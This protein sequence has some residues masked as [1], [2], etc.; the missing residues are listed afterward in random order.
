MSDPLDENLRD[1]LVAAARGS[2]GAV[3][4]VGGLLGEL[5]TSTI[6][7][8][9]QER[10]VAY[11][12]ALAVRLGQIETDRARE[13]LS[14]PHKID[15]IETGG[16][17]AVRATSQGRIEQIAE[18][19]FKGL[20]SD[21]AET[22]R[23]KRLLN[24]FG[25]LDDDEVTILNAYGQNT[26]GENRDIWA[27]INRPPPAHLG[28]TMEDV[29]REKLFD[30]GIDRLI[31]LGLLRRHYRSVKKGEMPE[32]DSRTGTFRHHVDVSVLGRM[33]LTEIGLPTPFDQMRS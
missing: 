28:S 17:Q 9:R 24:L 11:L 21:A 29:G 31:S 18:I 20:Q 3:P 23:R 12:K 13:A 14:D 30:L 2:L 25:E 33:L 8:Q 32:F 19:V 4:F 10:I 5:V 26:G 1:K 27:T 15:S 7:N 6:P 16:F 22:I